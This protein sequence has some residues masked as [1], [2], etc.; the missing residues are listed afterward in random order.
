MVLP[1]TW[2]TG[3][4]LM[5]G[6]NFN[7]MVSEFTFYMILNDVQRRHLLGLSLKTDVLRQ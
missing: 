1:E 5:V 3:W 2:K 6:G 4:I 7:R